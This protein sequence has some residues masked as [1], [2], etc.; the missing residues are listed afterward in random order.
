MNSQKIILSHKK[1]LMVISGSF[2]FLALVAKFFS[3]QEGYRLSMAISALFGIL[4]IGLQAYQAIK[5]KVI[6]IDLLVTIAI[7]GAFAI[8]EYNEAAIVAF[9]FLF[10][11]FLEQK[12]LEKTRSAIQSLVQLA[13]TTAWKFFE[14]TV[15]KIPID[16]VEEDDLLLVKTGAQVPV[17]GVVIEGEG[18]ID[19]SSVTGEAQRVAKKAKDQV[20][21]GTIL[22]NGTLKVQAMRVGEET[23]FGKIIELVEEAQDAKSTTERFIDR[24]AT[25]YT[26][27]VL[28]LAL[29]IGV[30]S[31]DIR[32]AITI[33]VLGC[34]GA[35]II[36]V[37]VSNVAGIGNGA[38]NGVLVKGSEV[39][40]VFS[41][42]DTM[43]FDKTGTLTNGKPSVSSVKSYGKSATN[44]LP[45]VARIEQESDHPLGQAIV[46]YVEKQMGNI[47]Q[48]QV[49]NTT[50]I[51]GK[52]II[53]TVAGEKLFIGNRQLLSDQAISLSEVEADEQRLQQEGNSLVFVATKNEV[54][55]LIGIKDQL[56]EGVKETLQKLQEKGIKRLVML[57]GDNQL[58][59]ES[60]GKE[61]GLSEIHGNLLPE[62]KANYIK[63]IQKEGQ[64]VAFV[65]DGINDSPSLAI[66][67]IGIAMGNGTDVAVETSDI[68]LMQS[69]F[70]KLLYAFDL[71]KKSVLNMKENIGIALGTVLFLLI[72]L[73]FG[74]VYMAS[75]MLF[76]ELSILLVVFNSMR[77]LSYRQKK[78]KLDRNQLFKETEE[79]N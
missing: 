42:V 51:K 50:V 36:G 45:F 15:E 41:R 5:V 47:E 72:G 62:E 33:L 3:Y 68:V 65:G 12:T 27:F 24:F 22:E 78:K 9:L 2:I 21:A 43:V 16:E 13:P 31:K 60:I 28:I 55:L 73:I 30:F 34:P 63:K 32:L 1:Q 71:T 46:K 11:H 29:L 69:D 6:S 58:T 74:Y 61:I 7:F 44:V 20:F 38:K 8:G 56:R 79:L 25:Y 17:D 10:G 4:P 67:D 57:S 18:S 48:Y 54:V 35:L 75:G 64:V 14:D 59:A 26:P 52:G 76:H 77:L 49:T 70:K 53:A 39:M 40:Q 19:E 37:P 23:T 66:A